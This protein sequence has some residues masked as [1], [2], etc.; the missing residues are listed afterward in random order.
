MKLHLENSMRRTPQAIS[1][2]CDRW[3][4]AYPTGSR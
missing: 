4:F 1:L 2:Q 3:G